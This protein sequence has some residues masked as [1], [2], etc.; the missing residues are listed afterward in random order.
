MGSSEE[1]VA[2]KSHPVRSL[3]L[4][5]LV[6]LL[7]FA[8]YNYLRFSSS[9][10]NYIFGWALLSVP[11]LALRPL[12]QLPK[13]AKIIGYISIAPALLVSLFLILLSVA[14]NFDLHPYSSGSCAQELSKIEEQGYTV[15]LIRDG[16]G[17]AMVSF[18]VYV[19]QRRPVF[20]GIYLYREVDSFDEAYEGEMSSVGNSQIRI[21]IPRGVEGSGWDRSVDRVYTLKRHVYF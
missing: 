3:I 19:E 12:S 18:M 6:F 1:R 5:G 16:C 14:W 21:Q 7:G 13:A 2:G 15:H 9:L 10:L 8:C 20:P 4:L 17:G 11:F